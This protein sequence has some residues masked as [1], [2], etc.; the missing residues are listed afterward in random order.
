M[1]H[2]RVTGILVAW[3]TVCATASGVHAASVT[4]NAAKDNTIY[5]ESG[6]SNGAGQ[7]FFAGRNGTGDARRALIHFDLTGI[8]PA[9]AT[10]DSVVLRLQVVQTTADSRTIS[11]HGLTADWGEGTSV[12]VMGEGG[13]APA[14]A[15][16]ATWAFRFF[17]AAQAWTTPGGDFNATASASRPVGQVGVYSWR[18]SGMT[19][20]VTSWLAAPSSNVGWELIGDETIAGTAKAF[21]S[22]Q[23]STVANRPALTIYYTEAPTGAGELPVTTR[24]FPVQPNPFNPSATIRYHLAHG[25]SVRLA[26]YDVQGKLIRVLMEGAMPA[27]DHDAVWRGDDAS[28]RRVASGVYLARLEMPGNASQTEKMV[29]LK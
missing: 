13:G 15:N 8:V 26:V 16:D 27:G 6:N 1:I 23:A 14:S 19:S 11:L 9:G 3:V 22:R 20:D 17:G 5:A 29:L 18:S 12:G 4:V 2:S 10:V 25:M 21:G 24:L 28:G 7:R